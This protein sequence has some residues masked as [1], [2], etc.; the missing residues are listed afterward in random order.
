[1]VWIWRFTWVLQ[2]VVR[3]VFPVRSQYAAS[4][5]LHNLVSDWNI[6]RDI[7]IYTGVANVS[8]LCFCLWYSAFL[9]QVYACA[10][11]LYRLVSVIAFCM[12]ENGNPADELYPCLVLLFVSWPG[13]NWLMHT[14]AQIARYL[15][16]FKYQ[17]HVDDGIT[18]PEAFRP[19]P[20]NV[21]AAATKMF[22]GARSLTRKFP[23]VS[24][25]PSHCIWQSSRSSE[26]VVVHRE[27]CTAP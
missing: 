21:R 27:P 12:A 17:V 23:C 13:T 26:G 2:Y 4:A 19:Q 18:K 11:K 22:H 14:A 3:T 6:L 8:V 15:D 25:R 10:D 7:N 16:V 1:M 9:I 24:W 20:C 5:R